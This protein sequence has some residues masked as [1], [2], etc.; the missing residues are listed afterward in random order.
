M[1]KDELVKR[2]E[3]LGIAIDPE[4]IPKNDELKKL[5]KNK[6]AE[7]AA[8]AE[9]AKVEELSAKAKDLGIDTQGLDTS[10]ALE[11]A[12]SD[13]K[14]MEELTEK[15]KSLNVDFEDLSI[16]QLKKAIEAAEKE[17]ATVYNDDRGLKWEF[18]K[19]APATINIDG[20]SM[21]QAE[22]METE[23]VMAELVYGNSNFLI[24]IY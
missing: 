16:A 3:E 23:D 22:I 12:I 18:K 11:K 21:T 15:A 6:E 2:C 10:E 8:A 5:I 19:S 24:Q 17:A 13:K 14:E 7:N 1:N 20:K 9:A 4:N